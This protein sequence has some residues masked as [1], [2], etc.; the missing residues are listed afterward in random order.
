MHLLYM[1][2]SYGEKRDIIVKIFVY[3]GG[4]V[5]YGRNKPLP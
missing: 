1:Y 3:L 2:V 4:I 5:L